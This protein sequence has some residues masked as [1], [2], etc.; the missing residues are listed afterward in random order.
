LLKNACRNVALLIHETTYTQ[1]VLDKVGSGPMHSSAKIVAEF[2]Q[3]MS[4]PNLIATH[5][6][7]RYHDADGV[8]KIH[9]EI[10]EYYHGHFYI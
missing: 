7:A 8:Q 5:L 9:D 3:M 1:A 2:A 10:A 6:S 4:L